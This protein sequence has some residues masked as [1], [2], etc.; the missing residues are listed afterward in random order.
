MSK[1]NR[2]KHVLS[3]VGKPTADS[4]GRTPPGTPFAWLAL[5]LTGMAVA[6]PAS[7]E[8][9]LQ[10]LEAIRERIEAYVHARLSDPDED[11]EIEVGGLDPRLRLSAC[12]EPPEVFDPPTRSRGSRQVYGVRCQGP[13]PWKLYLP[14]TVNRFGQVLSTARSL[15]QGTTIGEGDLRWLRANLARLPRGYFQD[16]AMLLGRRL[17]RHVGAAQV[18][19]PD[20]MEADRLVQRGETVRITAGR[21]GIRVTMNGV[22]LSDGELGQLI[23]VRNL[24]SERVIRG[25]VIADGVVRVGP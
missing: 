24:S 10:S 9:P 13:R 14:V 6:L 7:S 17:K 15:P 12:Q 1:G 11:L 5:L 20:L 2:Q 19:S 23:R 3:A 25:E 18:L 21:R 16:E 4:S 22:A 8:P